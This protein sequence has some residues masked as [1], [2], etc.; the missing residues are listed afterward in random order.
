MGNSLS[1]HDLLDNLDME[2]NKI[3][4]FESSRAWARRDFIE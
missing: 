3:V 2:G 4:S 1:L